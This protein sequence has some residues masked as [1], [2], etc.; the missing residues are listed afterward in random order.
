VLAVVWLL[1]ALLTAGSAP[2]VVSA[3][4]SSASE[5]YEADTVIEANAERA[6]RHLP[7]LRPSSCLARFA[8]R[9]ARRMADRQ[10]LGHQGL[11]AILASCELQEVGENVAFGYPGAPAVTQGWLLSPAHRANL[12]NPAHRLIAVAAHQDADGRWYVS[13]VVGRERGGTS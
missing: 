10:A 3:T 4:P 9:Q 5:R 7:G 1:T 13:Q 12:L 6:H 2:V 8:D 11:Q